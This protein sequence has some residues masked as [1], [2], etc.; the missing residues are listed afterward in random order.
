MEL[1]SPRGHLPVVSRGPVHFQ[2]GY[3]P[4]AVRWEQ[5]T[6]RLQQTTSRPRPTA[7]IISITS[8]HMHPLFIPLRHS[9]N[10]LPVP[11]RRPP[12]RVHR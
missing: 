5:K 3:L 1:E 6:P 7:I 2:P 4:R 12:H 9:L 10:R 8:M 11:R